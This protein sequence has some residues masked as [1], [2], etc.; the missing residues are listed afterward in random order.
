MKDSGA[1][2]GAAVQSMLSQSHADF[3]LLAVDDGSRDDTCLRAKE[4]A[5]GD[6]RLKVLSSQG[7]G[8]VAALNTGLAQASAPQFIARMDADDESHP[9]RLEACLRALDDSPG[10]CAVGTQVDLFRDD[11]PVSPSL[12]A[13]GAWL[14]GHTNSMSLFHDR[15]VESPLCHPSVVMRRQALTQVGGYLDV[16]GPEDWHLW[17]R[18]LEAG[19]SLACVPRRLHRWRDHD[20]RLTRVDA[21]YSRARQNEMKADFLAQRLRDVG[22]LTV[23]GAGQTGLALSRAL[24]R[25]GRSTARF[26]DVDPRKIGQRIDGVRV[27]SFDS[28]GPPPPH[29]HL[30]AAVGSHGARTDIRS[31]LVG[32]GW[33]EG[34]HFTCAA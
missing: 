2:V 34:L 5:L 18:M 12:A 26:I 30:L 21:R 31:H 29:G 32:L 8:L 7:A 24:G 6:T 3:E 19:L 4:A 23:W 22:P 25:R 11:R 33:N 27:E 1:T 13:Y 20:A 9:E 28:L 10:L 15:Y 16:D 14:N 17:L